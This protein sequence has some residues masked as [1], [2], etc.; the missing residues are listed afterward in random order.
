MRNRIKV[1]LCVLIGLLILIPNGTP[2]NAQWARSSSGGG[3]PSTVN[4]RVTFAQ[5][6]TV[7]QPVYLLDGTAALP[8]LA[9]QAADGDWDNGFYLHASLNRIDLAFQGVKKWV[10]D[11]TRIGG[12][13]GYSFS[14]RNSDPSITTPGLYPRDDTN[15]GL[16]FDIATVDNFGILTGAIK[17]VLYREV[18]SHVLHE[19]EAHVDLTAV[20]GGV[21]GDGV[22]LS[23][24]N[25]ISICVD[26]GDAVTLPSTFAVGTVVKIKNDGGASADVFPA[27]GDN[28][29]A[30]VN[31]AA[32]LAAG[33]S[34]T[35]IGTAENSTWTSIGN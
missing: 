21:Q 19:V 17:A 25:V 29:G 33:A 28:L 6:I 10:F 8:A 24:Y 30:G 35:Y 14:L 31:T 11:A 34:I 7:S 4:K 9:F 1:V 2:V 22:L 13:S 15:T 12:D 20:G 32:A 27:L 3:I 23:S 18:A 16:I 26:V 5:G